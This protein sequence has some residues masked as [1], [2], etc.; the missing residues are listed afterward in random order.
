M[1]L[2]IRLLAMTAVAFLFLI[3]VL[4]LMPSA[5]T[6]SAE[7]PQQRAE[8]PPA[9]RPGPAAAAPAPFDVRRAMDY[10]RQ[11]CAI[12]PRVS[13]S[14][15]MRQQQELLKAHFEKLGGKVELQRFTARQT[16]RP[17]PVEM[18]NLIVTWHPDRTRR[19]LLCGHYDTRPR[20]DQ[21]PNPRRWDDP[22]VSAND[23]TSSVAWLMEMAHHVGTLPLNV[24]VDFALFDGEE[25][26]FDG[27]QG[28]DKYFFGSEH[29]AAEYRRKPPPHRYAAAVLLDLFAG[30]GARYPKEQNSL[31]QAGAVVDEVWRTARELGVT[32]FQ[33]QVGPA[34]ND[35]HIALN[36]AGIPAVDVI[37]FDYPHWHRLSDLPENCSGESM[38]Q[39]ARVLSV[40]LQRVR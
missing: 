37:D 33:D 4:W 29:F 16:S 38:E 23:G 19:V 21:E 14:A 1:R 8:R 3:G 10:L 30:K 36:R 25:Y 15:G 22:F 6:K 17:A 7:P 2:L 39:V 34:V 20:A 32:V 13:G 35:D 12:G 26:C 5:G 18:A 28:Q 40:W 31:F 11:V 9:G 24:G 27:P